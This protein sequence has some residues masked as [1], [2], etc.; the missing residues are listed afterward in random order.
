MTT[1]KYTTPGIFKTY[2]GTLV[3]G[4]LTIKTAFREVYDWGVPVAQS[5]QVLKGVEHLLDRFVVNGNQ[6]TGTLDGDKGMPIVPA[7][8]GDITKIFASLAS[9]GG[10]DI[11]SLQFFFQDDGGSFTDD[12]TAAKEATDNDVEMLPATPVADDATYFGI[13]L[14]KFKKITLVKGTDGV[15]ADLVVAWEYYNGDIWV[16]LDETDGSVAFSD[17]DGTEITWDIPSDWEAT[18]VD[19]QSAFWVR[20]RVV[21]LG[22]V[23]TQPLCKSIDLGIALI[24]DILVDGTSIWATNPENRPVVYDE[25]TDLFIENLNALID[26]GAFDKGSLITLSTLYIGLGSAPA[27]LE[28]QVWGSY[29]SIGSKETFTISESAGV[30]TITSSNP[31][32]ISQIELSCRGLV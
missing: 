1:E 13:E 21:S 12:S 25:D 4:S 28:V 26:D 27:D 2:Q 32:S 7:G 6:A 30:L 23:T 5:G 3:A 17:T 20:M 18:E 10:D 8:A 14:Y 29:D 24:L 15:I 9:L 22:A 19:S 31:E 11:T 16:D